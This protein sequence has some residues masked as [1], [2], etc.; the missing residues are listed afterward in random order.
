MRGSPSSAGES[1]VRSR[2]FLFAFVVIIASFEWFLLLSEFYTSTVRRIGTRHYQ[3]SLFRRPCGY[4]IEI[5]TPCN[6][7]EDVFPG[8]VIDAENAAF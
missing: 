1:I 3:S 7:G 8:L 5:R 4:Y 6:S 2:N